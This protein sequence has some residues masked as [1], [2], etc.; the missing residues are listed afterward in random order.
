MVQLGVK[1]HMNQFYVP[2]QITS[3]RVGAGRAL[4]K[5][6]SSF[7]SVTQFLFRSLALLYVRSVVRVAAPAFAATALFVWPF[8]L[9]VGVDDRV[10]LLVERYSLLRIDR[11]F[12]GDTLCHG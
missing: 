2:K 12:F 1:L 9:R 4:T 8:N 3:A 6:V 5:Q 7:A 10:F 11:F